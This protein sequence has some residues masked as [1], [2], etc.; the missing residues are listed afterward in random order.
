MHFQ[1]SQLSWPPGLGT[2]NW[3]TKDLAF[4]LDMFKSDLATATAGLRSPPRRWCMTVELLGQV[5]H[6]DVP[7]LTYDRATSG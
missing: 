5:K 1:S 3:D 2:R 6:T 7:R 4:H